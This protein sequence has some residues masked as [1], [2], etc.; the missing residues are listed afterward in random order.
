MLERER[1]RERERSRE[2]KR[3]RQRERISNRLPTELRG[4]EAPSYNQEI[5]LG[6]PGGSGV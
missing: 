6:S 1:E 4:C 2:G 5:H 3:G